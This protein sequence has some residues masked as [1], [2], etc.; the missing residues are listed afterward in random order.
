ME[1]EDLLK[2]AEQFFKAEDYDS[3]MEAYNYGINNLCPNYAPIW[4][5]RAAVQLKLGNYREAINDSS[6]ALQLLEPP[7]ESNALMRAKA[8]IRRGKTLH[9]VKET[10]RKFLTSDWFV[11]LGTSE[12]SEWY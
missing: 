7:V 9:A 11:E 3:A 5:N 4:N 2:K 6:K 12:D 1:P 10:Q 8:F